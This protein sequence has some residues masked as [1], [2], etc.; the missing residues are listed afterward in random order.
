MPRLEKALPKLARHKNSACVYIGGR[1]IHLGPWGSKQA[2][3]AYDRR[4]AEWLK[5]GRVATKQI[6][7]TTVNDVALAYV[8]HAKKYYVKNGRQTNEVNEIKSAIRHVAALYGTTSAEEFGPLA[9]ECVRQRMIDNGWSRKHINKQ[10]SRVTRMF[11]WAASRQLVGPHVPNSLS[12]L[13]GLKKNRSAARETTPVLPISDQVV[14]ATLPHLSSIVADMVRVQRCTGMRPTEVCLLRP[15]AIDQSGDVWLYTPD[16]HKNEHHYKQREIQI[17]PKAQAVLLKYL[18]RA[19]DE[20][21]FDP[22]EAPGARCNSRE[23]YTKDSYGRAVRRA[24]KRAKVELWSPNRL[25][26]A[27]A[28]EV[29][30][31]WGLEAAQQILGHASMRTSEVYAQRDRAV[32]A[33]VA[34]RSG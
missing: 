13:D 24:A 22:R 9:L 29:R 15:G 16:E 3:Q 7:D 19:D 12:T 28:T 20:Y 21:C 6:E 17:G 1:R 32:A 33:K 25:R 27:R 31:Q 18:L 14:E 34:L 11:K 10:V 2:Q 26:H 8:R 5:S 4:I 23:R 30:R